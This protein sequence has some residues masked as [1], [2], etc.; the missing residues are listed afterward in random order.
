MGVVS[1]EETQKAIK[2][3][4]ADAKMA[5]EE[6]DKLIAEMQTMSAGNPEEQAAE[7]AKNL[8]SLYD[9]MPSSKGIA[10]KTKK[11]KASYSVTITVDL[12]KADKSKLGQVFLPVDFSKVKDYKDA[13]KELK[14][15]QFKAEK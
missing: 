6:K 14:N 7:M 5:Q 1:A 8:D 9:N 15:L 11:S 2:E 10:V 3:I 12:A 13:E 4:E